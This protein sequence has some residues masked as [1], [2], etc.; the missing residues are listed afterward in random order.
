VAIVVPDEEVF[1]SWAERNGWKGTMEELCQNEDVNK[2][3]LKDLIS[4]GK[5]NEL[6]GF[7]QVKA[8][9]LHHELFS[10]ENDLLTPTMKNKRPQLKKRFAEEIDALYAKTNG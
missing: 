3:V 2:A 4:V 7:E 5:E 9:H 1:V 10:V 8:V 6:R